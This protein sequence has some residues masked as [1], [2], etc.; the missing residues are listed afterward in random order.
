[1]GKLVMVSCLVGGERKTAFVRLSVSP[2]GK[3]RLP[4]R[5][6]HRIFNPHPSGVI[7]FGF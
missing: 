7:C 2:G 3:V 5:D 4:E 6:F 1:M